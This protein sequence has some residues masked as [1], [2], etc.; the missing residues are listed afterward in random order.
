[1]R[2]HLLAALPPLL[3]IA[4][5]PAASPPTVTLTGWL[6]CDRC[7]PARLKAARLR[8]VNRDCA[9]RC[10]AEGA[11]V[12]LIDEKARRLLRVTNPE[13]T[14]GQEGHYVRVTGAVDTNAKTLQVTSVAVLEEYVAFCATRRQVGAR[15]LTLQGISE[16]LNKRR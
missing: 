8:P 4:A 15:S 5:Q 10:I 14:K 12:V 7:A 2:S 11:K 9:Q 13:V 3:L 16:R 1:M 6:A